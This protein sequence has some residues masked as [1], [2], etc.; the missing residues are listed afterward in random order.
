MIFER[1]TIVIFSIF[2][3]GF[4]ISF[5]QTIYGQDST[6]I[7]SEKEFPS[8]FRV[9]THLHTS[10]SHDARFWSEPNLQ[11]ENLKQQGYDAVLVSDHDHS[12]FSSTQTNFVVPPFKNGSFE[13]SRITPLQMKIINIPKS[14]SQY[15]NAS[16]SSNS[17]EGQTSFHLNLKGNSDEF[18]SLSWV[19]WER[20]V[21]KIRDRPIAYDLALKFSIFFS[22]LPIELDSTAYLCS[23]I[24][25]RQDVRYNEVSKKICFYFSEKDWNESN[26]F[27]LTENQ[28]NLLVRIDPPPLKTWK[29]YEFN[30]SEL[31]LDNFD[32]LEGVPMKYLMLKQVTFNLVSKNGSMIDL[33]LDNLNVLSKMTSAQ[34]FDWWKKDI[35]SYS[36][37]NFVVISGLETTYGQ[38]IAAY[39]LENWYNFSNYDSVTDRTQGINDFGALSILTSPRAHNFTEVKEG[40][41]W[42]SNLIEIFNTVHDSKPSSQVLKGWDSFL[43]KGV[44]ISGVAG[45]DSHGLQ[46]TPGERNP[47]VVIEPIYENIVYAESLTKENILSSLEKGHFFVKQTKYPILMTLSPGSELKY[48]MGGIQ[49]ISN[50]E[51]NYVSIFIKGAPLPSKLRIYSDGERLSELKITKDPF[52]TEVKIPPNKESYVRYEVLHLG[53]RIAFSNPIFFVS[54][55]QNEIDVVKES[56]TQLAQGTQ[57]FNSVE[58]NFLAFG[59]IL[60][61]VIIIVFGIIIKRKI[62]INKKLSN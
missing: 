43:S 14:S 62:S 32:E 16:D 28:N 47:T 13:K 54:D 9:V 44:R 6:N 23:T 51:E 12:T 30:L 61:I 56:P 55:S 57:N 3:M 15:L 38:D 35:E 18:D 4:L 37:E 59:I 7:E 22:E 41:G 24:G 17:Y 58:D 11:I 19:Y 20:G 8:T 36:E 31:A 21:D 60:S 27:P 45:F 49:N 2:V 53:E 1:K 40:D 33:H 50:N 46:M 10:F 48:Q 42:G 5:D 29:E 52:V 25:K 34:M 26:Y 39:G